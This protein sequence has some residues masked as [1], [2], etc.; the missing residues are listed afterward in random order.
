MTSPFVL[1]R[2]IH[3]RDTRQNCISCLRVISAVMPPRV[4]GRQHSGTA[5]RAGP[6]GLV[7]R[8]HGQPDV[9]RVSVAEEWV[10]WMQ[11]EVD[12]AQR[13]ISAPLN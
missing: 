11:S 8:H 3:A 12:P 5:D 2:G 4:P 13:C 9:E 10:P 6:E 7:Q 1:V